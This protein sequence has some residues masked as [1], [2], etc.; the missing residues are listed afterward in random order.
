M[1]G[2]SL[3]DSTEE[4]GNSVL[5]PRCSCA[6]STFFQPSAHGELLRILF[7]VIVITF[8]PFSVRIYPLNPFCDGPRT[9]VTRRSRAGI[10]AALIHIALI[11]NYSLMLLKGSPVIPNISNNAD[12][13]AIVVF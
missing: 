12:C 9:G 7:S 3:L 2:K 11:H 8:T 5:I 10:Q 4:S 13:A 6:L 1:S